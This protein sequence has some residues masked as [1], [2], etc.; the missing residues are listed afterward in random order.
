MFHK[1]EQHG[2]GIGA[3]GVVDCLGRPNLPGWA[4]CV[5]Q[6][7]GPAQSLATALGRPLASQMFEGVSVPAHTKLPHHMSRVDAFGRK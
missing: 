1:Q 6:Q 5:L 3:P 2:K 7:A 4:G